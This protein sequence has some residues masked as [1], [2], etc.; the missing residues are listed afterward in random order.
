MKTARLI[1]SGLVP[2]VA[3]VGLLFGQ[4]FFG[5]VGFLIGG[6]ICFA[7]ITHL[8]RRRITASPAPALFRL[9]LL[10]LGLSLPRSGLAQ[11]VTNGSFEFAVLPA[12]S[13]LYSSQPGF[14]APG[15]SFTSG[16]GLISPPSGFGSPAAPDGSQVAFLQSAS[17]SFWQTIVLPTNGLY[18]LGYYAAGRDGG[19][20]G[21]VTYSVLLDSATLITNATTFSGQCFTFQSISFT[22]SSGSHVLVFTNSPNIAGDNTAFFDFA[23]IGR[24]TN[25][26]VNS[27]TN[28]FC[29]NAVAMTSGQ[30]YS[31]NTFNAT[32]N[33]DPRTGWAANIYHGVWYKVTPTNASQRINISTCGSGF[34]TRL[35]VYTGSCGSW[36]EV[37]GTDNCN[38]GSNNGGL[39]CG[40][41]SEA[42]VSFSGSNTTYYVLA[43]SSGPCTYGNLQI[44]MDLPAP[45]T[46][47]TCAG[48][49][50]LTAGQTNSQSNFYATEVGDPATGWGAG[51]YRGLWYKLIVT[52]ASQ[53]VN[54]KT[55]GSGFDTRL[56]VY[57]GG[58]G[59]WTEVAGNDNCNDGSNNGGLACGNCGEAA[60]SFSGS[61]TTYFILA[62]SGGP[63]N[64]GTLQISVDLTAP[65]TND[66]CAGAITLTPG[67]TNS[68][69]NFYATEAG[70]P[71][72]GWGAGLY[73]GL[74]YK[75]IVTNASQRV[76]IKTCGS[77]FDTRMAVYTGSCGSWTE[78]AGND[79]CND[80]SINGGL[81]CGN[82]GEAA[83]SFSGSNT[84]YYILAGGSGPNNYGNLQISVDLT[85]PPTNDLCMGAITMTAGQTYTQ[86]VFYATETGDP[87]SLCGSFYRGVWYALT[88]P[89]GARFTVSTCN[90]DYNT[91]LSVFTNG[92]GSL[93]NAICN[94]DN[95]PA[96]PSSTRASVNLYDGGGKTYYILASAI[97]SAAYGQL[98]I[99]ASVEAPTNDLC[100]GAIPL[101]AGVPYTVNNLNA[102]EAGDPTN[103]VAGFARG[104]WFAYQPAVTGLIGVGTCGSTF[105][106]GLAVFQG[107]C[108]SL[109][110]VACNDDGGAVCSSSDRA[111]LNFTG[112]AGTTYYFLAGGKNGASGDLQILVTSVD[113][114]SSTLTTTNPAGGFPTAGRNLAANWTVLNQGTNSISTSWTDRLVLSNTTTH[115]VTLFRDFSGTHAAPAAGGY[116]DSITQPIPQ[117]AAGDYVLIAQADVFGEVA[118]TSKTNNTTSQLLFITNL[119]PSVTLLSPVN[120]PTN[121]TVSTK[122]CL[123]RLLT[124]SASPTAGSYDISRVE[125]FNGSSNVATAFNVFQQFRTNVWVYYGTNVI[126]AQV[127]DTFGLRG[128]SAVS[129]A[130]VLERPDLRIL[131]GQRATNGECVFCLGAAAG[132][133]YLVQVASNVQPTVAWFPYAVPTP[134]NGTIFFTNTPNAPK[135][136]FRVLTTP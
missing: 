132:T 55:C 62:G 57:T 35:A 121:S 117:I 13:F 135:R 32:T 88:P 40:N 30:V 69:S 26:V 21:N 4:T 34:D 108:N 15:W 67:Q 24:G 94:N 120:V 118:E 37:A 99:V 71:G 45:P 91:V 28:D 44:S 39:T 125:Y 48:A 105:N 2:R 65:P 131:I 113:L 19:F 86:A 115:A 38:D 95:G 134:S 25:I 16:G 66:T 110:N 85:A 100:S 8:R 50:T 106:T 74:W 63:Y 130:I 76:N 82:C 29:T 43:G 80:G 46:N 33:G 6:A 9:V 87:S 136:F 112:A 93:S 14:S 96:C 42:A 78:V 104:I 73:R 23:Q 119:P 126:T 5:A 129:T 20:G 59:S 53:R 90:S 70:D 84:T 54:I 122:V 101:E 75:L 31:N 12:N 64:S 72:T 107:P 83:V 123:P 77:S 52:N 98:Q 36:T 51:L 128:T 111:S 60:V 103:C 17:A 127:V 18:T 22:A 11:I 81:T 7:R 27:P 89:T 109:T 68:Q 61:N 114:V 41:C 124:L 102:T 10:G 1:T 56:A 92:C 3:G 79:N 97:D 133:N 47:D 116:Q 49:I 58:C